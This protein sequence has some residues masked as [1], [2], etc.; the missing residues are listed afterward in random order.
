MLQSHSRISI[1]QQAQQQQSTNSPVI[2]GRANSNTSQQ[3]QVINDSQNCPQ[4]EK[5][6]AHEYFQVCSQTVTCAQLAPQASLDLLYTSSNSS[7]T[8]LNER[9]LSRSPSTHR[10]QSNQSHNNSNASS[11]NYSMQQHQQPQLLVVTTNA[12]GISL[13]ESRD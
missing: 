10:T 5:V 8:L 13:Y 9:Q 3:Q 6:D 11:H 4:A 12:G 2:K 7:S 1:V